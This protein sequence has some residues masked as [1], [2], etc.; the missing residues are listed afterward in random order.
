M[1]RSLR[2]RLLAPLVAFALPVALLVVFAV[3]GDQQR[4]EREVAE[5]AA[6]IAIEAGVV[7]HRLDEA[8]P[9]C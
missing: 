8:H 5:H 4:D 7:K 2:L 1:S 3:R 9:Q 6:G